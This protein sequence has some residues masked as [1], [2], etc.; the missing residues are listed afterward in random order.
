MSIELMDENYTKSDKLIHTPSSYA[1]KNLIFAQETGKLKSL[2]EHICV[3]ENLE[4]YLF[5]IV[6]DGCGIVST[7]GKDYEAKKG[8][9]VLL[10]CR[11]HYEHKSDVNDPW[12]IR[13]VHFNGDMPERLFPVF[14]EGNTG[15][16][17]FTPVDGAGQYIDILDR[18][19]ANLSK[20]NVIAE[21][22]QSVILEQLLMM[23]L[24]D[25]VKGQDISLDENEDIDEDEFSTLRESVNEHINESN[26]ER[27]LSIQYGLTEENL[28][29]MF[30]A[31]YGISIDKYIINRRFNKA[32]ELLRFTIKPIE[33]IVEESGI[34]NDE[35]FEKLFM[36]NE[37][38]TSENYR[39]KW[40]QWIK[41]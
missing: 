31:K 30:E 32:K 14:T 4:S 39:K 3:R 27:I 13:W 25:V 15:S 22:N 16:P 17:V 34:K 38:M 9:A 28:S 40:S 36:N 18:L 7:G 37:G 21:I 12:E 1:R 10:D 33:E 23:C 6:L 24:N 29:N 8:D 35:Q 19:N 26:L 11:K 20:S 2:K 5:F 41:S